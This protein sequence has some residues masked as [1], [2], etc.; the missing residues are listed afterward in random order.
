MRAAIVLAAALAL[1]G[2]AN[3]KERA[4]LGSAGIDP[5]KE[6]W[7]KEQII[8]ACELTMLLYAGWEAAGNPG[9][10]DPV[11]IRKIRAGYAG[12][13][14]FCLTAPTTPLTGLAAGTAAIKA[15]RAELAAA[16]AGA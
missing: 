7:T 4:A 6:V 13:E 12:V 2:C 10:K 3:W 16:K 9:T 15:F 8:Q 14:A 1:G 11:V 5:N